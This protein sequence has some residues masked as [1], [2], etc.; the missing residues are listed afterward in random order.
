MPCVAC[1]R[2]FHAFMDIIQCMDGGDGA[3][4]C[5]VLSDTFARVVRLLWAW[6][7]LAASVFVH[8]NPK[9]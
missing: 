8:W 7:T 2:R 6:T 4:E 9:G 3:G 5:C 1:M